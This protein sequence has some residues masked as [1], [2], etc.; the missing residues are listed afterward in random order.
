MAELPESLATWKAW[1]AQIPDPLFWTA[2]GAA[3]MVW[4]AWAVGKWGDQIQ[5]KFRAMWSARERPFAWA[6]RCLG[7]V[8]VVCFVQLAVQG[9]QKARRSRF[10]TRY[11][12]LTKPEQIRLPEIKDEGTLNF[13]LR[14]PAGYRAKI[15]QV[16][17]LLGLY[18]VVPAPTAG[19]SYGPDGMTANIQLDPKQLQLM[20]TVEMNWVGRADFGPLE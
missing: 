15:Q 6:L 4:V 18:Q 19:E 11:L 13:H 8:R 3:A 17:D 9:Q 5:A 1:I 16:V 14:A 7:L 20:V 2:I 12:R 10:R